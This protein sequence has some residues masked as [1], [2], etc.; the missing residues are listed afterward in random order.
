MHGLRHFQYRVGF[1]EDTSLKKLNRF[2]TQTKHGDCTELSHSAA[3]MG[4]M[5]GIPSRIVTGYVAGKWTQK[6]AHR[7]GVQRL[8][9]Q[10][11]PLQK[12]PLKDLYLVTTA[13][14]HAWVQFY[15]PEYGWINFESTTH[16]KPPEPKYDRNND[17]VLIPDIKEK[18]NVAKEKAKSEFNWKG[19]AIILGIV[20]ALFF[21]GLYIFRF[22]RE[23]MLYIRSRGD[24]AGALE[25]LYRLVLMR[26]AAVGYPL[27]GGHET[28]LEYAGR[29]QETKPLAAGYTM[30]R[31]RENYEPGE[32]E[33]TRKSLRKDAGKA[34]GSARQK[35]GFLGFLGRIFSLRGLN[36]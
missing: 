3:I 7:R 9:K 19:A 20:V 1:D 11:K 26:L 8:R 10:I 36:Y 18:P 4:R 35:R 17:D 27:K 24:D 29:V 21:L 32:K 28:A 5:A 33:E 34:V 16:A 23:F 31:Y 15:L 25:A 6:K 2:M 14:R 12:F 30:L 22:V 13:H